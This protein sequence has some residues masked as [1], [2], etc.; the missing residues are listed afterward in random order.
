MAPHSRSKVPVY[1][2]L[3]AILALANPTVRAHDA[4]AGQCS[5][6][7]VGNESAIEDFMRKADIQKLEDV[8]IGVTKPRRAVFAPGG[9]VARAAWKALAPS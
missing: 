6:S 8:P 3:T 7:W 5:R 9:P 2:V 1:A 4:Q